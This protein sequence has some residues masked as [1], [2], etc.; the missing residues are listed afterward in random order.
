MKTGRSIVC[1][2]VIIVFLV[3][4]LFLLAHAGP[5]QG[6][7][8]TP[9]YIDSAIASTFATNQVSMTASAAI[10]KAAPTSGHYRYR[11]TIKNCGAKTVYLGS[12]SA[13]TSSTGYTLATNEVIVLSG[14][15]SDIY[16]ICGGTD[17]STVCYLEEGR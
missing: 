2:S 17:T 15:Y 13:V 12:T 16:G 8:Q 9:V 4:S 1:A 5:T 10:I 3:F 7:P 11:I 6:Q 14:N